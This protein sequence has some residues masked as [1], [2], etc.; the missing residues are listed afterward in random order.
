MSLDHLAVHCKLCLQKPPLERAFI[1]YRK[2]RSI[3]MNSFNDD[4]KKSTLLSRNHNELSSLLDEYENTLRNILDEYAPVKRRMITLRPSAPW[5]TDEIREEKKKRRRLER[6]WRSSRS[7]L[8]GKCMLN[9][10]SLSTICSNVLMI[11]SNQKILFNTIDN[12]LHRRPEKRYPTASSTAEL[13]NNL[14]EFFHN[15]IVNIQNALFRYLFPIIGFVWL[16]NR[17]HA[18]LQ[19]SNECL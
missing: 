4:L 14:A 18:S 16:M 8:T 7:A 10:A 11:V 13:A 17:H 5:Y 9:S 3:D 6:R 19:S 2:I 1:L 12:L 15:K